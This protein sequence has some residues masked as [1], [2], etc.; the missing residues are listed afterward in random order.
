MA[1]CCLSLPPAPSEGAEDACPGAAGE[2]SV[3]HL[4][5]ENPHEL[6]SPAPYTS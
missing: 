2:P 1:G 6:P 5:G 4:A 3:P